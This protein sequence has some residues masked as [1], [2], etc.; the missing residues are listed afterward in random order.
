MTSCG[1][2]GEPSK[3]LT[4]PMETIIYSI[5]YGDVERFIDYEI[6]VVCFVQ[7]GSVSTNGS[8]FC[9]PLSETNLSK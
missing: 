7:T 4:I 8:I 2:V 6:G 1:T 5:K 9:V 3:V